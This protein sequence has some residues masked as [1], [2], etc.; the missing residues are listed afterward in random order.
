MAKWLQSGRRRDM[1]VLL[2]AAA[3]GELSGQRLKTRLE[4]RYDTRIEPKSFYGALEALESAGFVDHREDGIADKY[5]LTDAGER[6]L[7]D[8]FEWMQAA[9][10]E[11]S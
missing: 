1:C 4:R 5:S 10:G 2:A 9:L 7:R 6:R 3:D 8:Q 11:D